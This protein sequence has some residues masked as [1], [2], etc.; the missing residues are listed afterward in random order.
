MRLVGRSLALSPL[1]TGPKPQDGAA[2]RLDLAN[3]LW[4][5]SACQSLDPHPLSQQ[6]GSLHPSVYVVAWVNQ[7]P[8]HHE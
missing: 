4:P 8:P 1:H 7:T 2:M 6:R 3:W 5:T